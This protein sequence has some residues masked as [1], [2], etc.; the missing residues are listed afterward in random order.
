[1]RLHQAELEAQNA[2]LR[3]A[4]AGLQ[5]AREELQRFFDTVPVGLLRLNSLGIV[6]QSNECARNLVNGRLEAGVPF[7]HFIHPEDRGLFHV[8]WRAFQTGSGASMQPIEVRMAN[9]Q[10]VWVRILRDAFYIKRDA[11]ISLVLHDI[12]DIRLAEK[13]REQAEENYIKTSE[14]V[15]LDSWPVVWHMT[16]IISCKLFLVIR[17]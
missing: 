2:E 3:E 4:N 1:M 16:S 10:L 7:V 11:N 12:T 17:K 5:Y 15:Q 6:I 14:C 8:R 9:P 13:A